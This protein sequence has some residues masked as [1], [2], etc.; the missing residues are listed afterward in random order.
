L[1]SWGGVFQRTSSEGGVLIFLQLG[2]EKLLTWLVIA[3]TTLVLNSWSG[4][5]YT[6]YG[7]LV[8]KIIII[9]T[10]HDC[11]EQ[12]SPLTWNIHY[13]ET[14]PLQRVSH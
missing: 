7:Q 5:C 6:P 11:F 13:L 10:V 8:E 12:V 9:I 14:F 1:A 4:D 3:P 2:V